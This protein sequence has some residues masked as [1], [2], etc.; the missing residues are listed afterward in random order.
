MVSGRD[1]EVCCDAA[2][3]DE[4]VGDGGG[5]IG[6]FYESRVSAHT[7]G[8][9]VRTRIKLS[10]VS[11]QHG[12]GRVQLYY[13]QKRMMG[14]EPE[15]CRIRGRSKILQNMKRGEEAL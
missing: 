11:V 13:M 6:V 14:P 12:D 5:E 3:M 8:A 15:T 4:G 1:G 9:E 10:L 7:R 2:R